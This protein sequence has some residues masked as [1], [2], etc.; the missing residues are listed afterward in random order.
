MR[1]FAVVICNWNKKDDVEACINAVMASTVI[2][3]MVYVVDNA[4]TDGSQDVIRKYV[5]SKLSLIENCQNLGGSGGFNT[6]ISA[7]L[8]EGY[9][10]IHLLDNDATVEADCFEKTIELL[11]KEPSIVAVGS[12][13]LVAHESEPI[14]Q[15]MG[16]LIDWDRCDFNRNFPF[17]KD[18]DDIPEIV[19]CDYV[20]ACS[21]V[22]RADVIREVGLMDT[23]NFIYWDDIEWFYRMKK[24]GK[25]V[26]SYKNATVRHKLGGRSRSNTFGTYYFA[27]NRINFFIKNV[28]ESSLNKCVDTLFDELFKGIFFSKYK[29]QFNTAKALEFAVR[30]AL[31]NVRGLAGKGRILEREITVGRFNEWLSNKKYI[32]LIVDNVDLNIISE[33]VAFIKSIESNVVLALATETGRA[34]LKQFNIPIFMAAPKS[35]VG[36]EDELEAK[37][38]DEVFICK[39]CTHI[40]EICNE[41][42]DSVDCYVDTFRNVVITANDRVQ[43]SNYSTQLVNA[44]E[45]YLP[46]IMD[47][48]KHLRSL[49]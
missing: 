33:I 39:V 2:P 34:D 43:V 1:G 47:K 21:V 20:P 38:D 28:G 14:I 11:D 18:G 10:Y 49:L 9:Q 29:G 45:M 15:E 41:I 37:G 22:I 40:S 25:R 16:A 35:E 17:H 42:D 30:D 48:V 12:K 23:D 46:R 6:G 5:G 7:A 8:E 26:V 3:D 13:V 4:S 27:R 31:E 44:K 24:L 36:G 32:C 19:E